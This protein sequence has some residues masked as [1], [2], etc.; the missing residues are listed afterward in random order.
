MTD[1]EQVRLIAFYLPQ[2]HP[3]PENDRWWGTGFTEWT[4]VA[5]ARPWFE[6]HYQPHLP[7]ELGFYDLRVPEVRDEQAE[8]ARAHGVHGFCYHYYW[9][10]GRRLLERP[11]DEMLRSGRPDF[12]F[13]VCWANENWTR[14]WDGADHEVLIAQA[15]SDEDDASFIRSLLPAF[16]DARYIHLDGRPLLILYRPALMPD[17]PRTLGI[18]RSVCRGAGLP[19]PFVLA[20]LTFD[21][22]DPQPFGVDGAVEFPPHGRELAALAPPADAVDPEFRGAIFDY[23]ALAR[24]FLDRP[25]PPYRLFRTVMPGWDNTPRR[26]ARGIVF[27]RSTPEEYAAWL[28]GVIRR[29]R[30]LHPPGARLV[31]INAWNEWGEGAHLEPDRRFGRAYLAATRDVADPGR[32][33]TSR[34]G[35][36]AR[37]AAPPAPA[38]GDLPG[39]DELLAAQAREIEHLRRL[40]GGDGPL[41]PDLRADP[42]A[43]R[44][45]QAIRALTDRLERAAGAR[46]LWSGAASVPLDP[47]G[48]RPI[49]PLTLA[50]ARACSRQLERLPRVKRLARSI[51]AGWLARPRRTRGSWRRHPGHDRRERGSP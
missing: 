38:A 10:G 48:A 31:F 23:G 40:L 22:P 28:E 26:G 25:S 46:D 1:P 29:T 35:S 5:A 47:A 30:A 32:R 19:P 11:F 33:R 45:V 36:A 20:A 24:Q 51:V 50:V 49:G 9:F 3:I 16:R 8:L 12:P 2:F 37:D 18:W 13:C 21:T 17:V 14:R 4:N 44:A 27:H 39:V 7:S 41:R 42:A 43:Q 15:H 34:R 6:G